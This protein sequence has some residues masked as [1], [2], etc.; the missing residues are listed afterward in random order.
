MN[1]VA[2]YYRGG[3]FIE[4]VILQHGNRIKINNNHKRIKFLNIKEEA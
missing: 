3:E 2:I 4:P 1:L